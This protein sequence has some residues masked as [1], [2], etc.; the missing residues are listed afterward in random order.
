MG[1]DSSALLPGPRRRL[2]VA[3]ETI[4][5]CRRGERDGATHLSE[6][7][8][9]PSHTPRME[10]RRWQWRRLQTASTAPPERSAVSPTRTYGSRRTCGAGARPQPV[11]REELDAD[12]TADS[13][14]NANRREVDHRREQQFLAERR[15]RVLRFLA[16]QVPVDLSAVAEYVLEAADT[17][18]TRKRLERRARAQQNRT[19]ERPS[20]AEA[21]APG[22]QR[23]AHRGAGRLGTPLPALTRRL[24]PARPDSRADGPR[25]G[26]LP[27]RKFRVGGRLN[28]PKATQLVATGR[29]GHRPSTAGQA[30]ERTPERSLDKAKRRT[31]GALAPGVSQ[32]G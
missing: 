28:R 9:P 6:S 25:T 11:D 30:C 1:C 4:H 14:E 21:R 3:M 19:P 16:A 31:P 22:D 13:R 29:N 7:T 24:T 10:R 20:S 12:L 15:I 17:P 32:S 8:W 27:S 26:V 5:E 2:L 18:G 23:G